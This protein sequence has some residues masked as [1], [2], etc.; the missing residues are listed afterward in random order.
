M[1]G[2]SGLNDGGA[3]L[4]PATLTGGPGGGLFVGSS[5]A[6]PTAIALN[7]ATSPAG[8]A[9]VLSST[10]IDARINGQGDVLFRTALAGG[11][12]DSALF[13]RRGLTGLTED[14]CRARGRR[15]RGP[16]GCSRRF[17]P[18]LDGVPG[19][20]YYLGPTGEIVFRTGLDVSGVL[21]N[22]LFRYRGNAVLETG[23][24]AG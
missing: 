18:T 14:C 13:V 24:D 5:A 15:V 1:L 6:A 16:S 19:E 23:A 21:R 4:F 11:S 9:Y 17:G 8:G 2:A 22:G 7:G 3:V 10:S 12:S 20:Y